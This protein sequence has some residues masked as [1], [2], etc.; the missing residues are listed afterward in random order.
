MFAP[1]ESVPVATALADWCHSFQPSAADLQLAQRS[2]WD[3]VAVA[4]AG[5]TEP[6]LGR[7]RAL[8]PAGRWAVAAH[9]L[10]F[11][12]LHMASTAHISAVIVP[13]VLACGGGAHAYL[14]GAG[15]MAR[16]GSMLGWTHYS[17][18]WHATCTSGAPG[19]AAAASVA[20][21]LDA[22]QTAHAIALAIPAAGGVQRAFGT[23]AKS[24]QVG[25]AADA[26]VRAAMLAADGAMGDPTVVEQWLELLN[27][28]STDVDTSGPAVPGGLAIKM[29]PCCYAMQRP[30][31]AVRECAPDVEADR[32]ERVIVRTPASSVQ[33]L[34]H[35]RPTTGLE[36][37]FSM[38]YAIATAL[39]D[40]FP[41][42]ESFTSAAVARPAAQRLVDVVEVL[43][44]AGG[45]G[46]LS[47]GVEIEL[48]LADGDVC[49]AAADVPP[50]AP[51][52][53][54][55]ADDMARKVAACDPSLVA[56]LETM[57]WSD[58]AGLLDERLSGR[59]PAGETV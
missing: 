45:D 18:G 35:H 11:D 43:T 52:R 48:H 58:A 36:G 26:G 5:A 14:A 28:A 55:S 12:D 34:I 42:L 40:G 23:D 38:E 25:F 15:V 57:S 53:P 24:L 44:T 16:L 3:T 29:H 51:D 20:F 9:I 30:I 1:S 10:D 32:V 31:A 2:L 37:K 47:G 8:G 13:T 56:A 27:A 33:P 49:R 17:A 7:V 22:Q 19:A 6:V 39:L 4:C 41:G 46:L 59:T 50:G 21:G 54:P